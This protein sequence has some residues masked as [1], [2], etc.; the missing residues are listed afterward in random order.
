MRFPSKFFNSQIRLSG[1][2]A[3]FCLVALALLIHPTSV[4]ADPNGPTVSISGPSYTIGNHPFSVTITFSESVT[5]FEQDDVTVSNASVTEFSG[6]GSSYSVNLQPSASGTVTVD[7]AENVATNGAG[8]GNR[9]ASQYSGTVDMDPPSVSITGPSAVQTGAFD[10]DIEFSE[11]VGVHG[12]AF[13]Q[14]DV[15][16][17]NGSVT[18]FSGS[19][20]SYTATITPSANGTVT[21]DV[22]AKVT[23][24]A[25]GNN[26]TA[27]SQF[28]VQVNL[29]AAP[30]ITAPGNKTY[31]QGDT[32]TSFG[33]PVS[34]ADDDALS[35]TILNLPSGLTWSWDE[36]SESLQVTGTVASG[37]TAQDYKVEIEVNDQ[38]NSAVKATFT[39]TVLSA[40]NQPPEFT[41]PS[42][43]TY[44]QGD[45]IAAFGITVSDPDDY[46]VNIT[47][48]MTGLP[49][50]LSYTNGQV[51]GTVASD[52][53]AKD[54][55]VTIS[56]TDRVNT[57]TK[58]FTIRVKA[59]NQPPVIKAPENKTYEQGE[60][61][62]AFDITVTDPNEDP[63]TVTVSGLP[64]GLS[65]TNGQVQGTVAAN[66]TEKDYTV[67]I[68]ANEE[69]TSLESP[70]TATFTITV[71]EA[72]LE[73]P[74][75]TITG[76]TYTIGKHSFK[77]T[78]TFSEDVTGFEQSD[79]TVGNGSVKSF[80]GSGTSYEV[81][82]SPAASGTV[83][84][85]VAAN[86]A[87]DASGNGN[88]AASQFSVTADQDAPTVTIT[89]PTAVQTGAFSVSIEFS[90]AIDPN[91]NSF[92]QSDVTVGNGSV[93]AFSGSGAS[94]TATITPAATGTVTVDVAENA[95]RD[96]AGNGNEAASQFSVAADIDAP[97]VS[98]TGPTDDQE[99]AFD[100][101]IT[102]SE[103]VTGFEKEDVTVGNG[104]VTAFSGS[105]S[106]YTATITPTVSR[107]ATVDVAANVAEDAAGNNN[108]AASQ[109]SV[110]VYL[111]RWI[112]FEGP[113][114]IRKTGD[115]FQVRAIFSE[116]PVS[117]SLYSDRWHL[118][119]S[120]TWYSGQ[121]VVTFTVTPGYTEK[122]SGSWPYWCRIR[123]HWSDP[124]EGHPSLVATYQVDV[125]PDPPRFW[126][127]GV[128]GPTVPQNGPFNVS[129]GVT[130][131]NLVGFDA[132]DIT[133]ENGSVTSFKANSDYG[134]S[135]TVQITPAASGYVRVKVGAA[136]FKDGTG[137]DNRASPQFSVLADLDAP[138]VSIAGPTDTQKEPFDVTITFSEDV[139]GFEQGDVT[140]GNGTVTAFSGSDSSYTAT[141]TPTATGTVTVDVAA[142]VAEDVAT[143][144]NTAA[145]QF[146]VTADI[147][148][149]TVSITGPTDN[150]DSAFDVTITFSEDVT[151]FEQSDVT[152]GNGTVT[153]FSGSGTSY[154][155]TI[156]PA[157][158]GIVTV[159]VPA[160][161][162]TDG[163]GHNNEAASQFSVQVY[164]PRSIRFEGPTTVR[165]TEDPFQVKVIFSEVPE[166]YSFEPSQKNST[167]SYTGEGP[168][169]DLTLTPSYRND[170]RKGSWPYE[171]VLRATWF[172]VKNG[173]ATLRG[174][175]RV[176]VDADPPR[177]WYSSGITGPTAPQTGPFDVRLAA[178]EGNL[179]GFDA[180]DITVTNGTVTS[181]EA[182]TDYGWN[183]TVQITPTASGNVTVQVGAA[184][185]KDEAGHDN[186]ASR[187]FTVLAD[188]DAPTVSIT[189]PTDT[190][191]E[192]FDVT[193]TFSEDVTG[194]EQSDVTVGNGSI[195]AFSGSNATYT[196]TITPAATGTVTVDVPENVATDVVEKGNEAASQFSVNADLDAPTVTITGPTDDQNS[197]FDVTITFSESV[198]GFE[199]SDVTVGNGSVTAFSGSEDS[200]TATITPAANGT[201]TV[202]VPANVANDAA[203]NGNSAASQFAVTADFDAPTVSITGPTDP[204]N[205]AF[206]VTITFSESV[207]GFEQ[208]DITVGN[209]FVTAFS[210]SEDS[211]TATITPAAT[212]TVTVD[213][214]ADVANDVAGNSN[215]AASQF[216]VNADLD[217]PTVSITGP[218]DPQNSTFDV[219]IT[220]SEDVTGFEQ[221]DIAVGKGSITAFSG[222]DAT[223]T[224]TITP[225]GSGTVTVDVPA[226]IATDAAGNSNSAASQFAVKLKS[227]RTL[228][229]DKPTVSITGPTDPQNSTFDVT[230]T[231]S[232]DVTGFEQSEVTV[233]N[234]FV[235]AFSG[236]EAT[237]T[238][239]IAPAASGTVT[240]DVPE[241]AAKDVGNNGNEAASQF[242]VTADLDAPL[243]S[244]TGP[245]D[246]QNSAF[247]I[248]ITFTEAVTGFEQSD[249][250]VGNGAVT[251]FSGSE[252][253]YTATITPAG[254]GTV[255]VNVPANVAT[256]AAGNGNGAAFS[257]FTA[258]ITSP[259]PDVDKPTV[260]I[261][262]PTDDQ[263]SAF[264]VT[265]TFS[266]AVTGFEQNDITVG[267]GTATA[268]S[269]SED[270]YTA[271][272]TPTASGTVTVDVPAD[273]ATNG[274]TAASQFSV[275]ADL[276]RPTVT[277]TGPTDTQK[278]PFDLTITFSESVT[279]FEQ[280]DITV[281]NGAVTAFSGTEA[282][283]TVS[284]TPAANGT[285]TVD[286]PE[287]VATDGAGNGNT[288]A[289]SQFS[290][291]ANLI[292]PT[293][294][295]TGPTDDQNSAFDITITFSESVTGFEQSEVT[296]GNGTVT[297]FSGA[298]ATYTATI[299]PVASGTVTVDVPADVATDSA[300]NGNS[301][302]SQF[303]VTADLDAP[304]V[305]ITGP[306]DDQ[307]SAFDVTITFSESVT[308]F[309]QSEVTVGNGAVTAFSGSED[310]YTVTITP[311]AS[312]TVTVDIA[313]NVATDGAGNGNTAAASQFS[314]EANLTRPTVVITGPTDAQNSAF[315]V[316]ITFSESVTG[317]EQS[318]VT[319]GNGA[320]T[321][322]SGSEASYT[323]TIT[324][325]ANGTV[326]VDVPA[327]VANDAAG[328]GNEAASQFAVTADL[329][330]PTVT[331][332]GP[333]DPQNSA[334]D[335]TITFSESVTGFEQSEV[336]V[337]NG[338]ATAFSGSGA[339]YTV[340]ITP[341]AN[342][343]VTVDV[344]ANVANDAAGNGNS[345]AASQFAV[346]A[347]LER[348]TVTITGPTD[349]Q[350][351][352]FDITITFSA[353]VTGFEQGDI[354]VGNGA[355][356]AF[357][358]TQAAYTVTITPAANGTVTVDVAANV[359]EDAATNGNTAASQFSV[360]AD[361]E[362][363]TVTITGPTDDQ[364]STFDV[365]I[366]FSESVTGFEQ[367]DIT[368]GNGTA[369]A[370]SGSGATYT[371]T[372]TPTASGTITVDVAA[373]VAEDAA[374]NSNTAAGQFSVTADLERPT[375]TITGPT[376]DQNS[377]FDVTI[378]FSEAV[379]G[380]EQ[381]D[382]T[383]GNSSVTAFSGSGATYTAT[384][385]PTASGTITVDVAADVATDSAGNGNTAAASQFSVKANLTRP[386]V[387][388]TGPTDTQNSA[389]DVTITFSE[390]VTGFEQSDVTIG[391]GSITAFSGSGSSYTATITPAAS[392]T[393]TVDVSA[394]VATDSAGNGN[395]AASQFSVTTDIDAPTVSITGPTDPQNSAFDITITFSESVTGFEQGDITVGNGS[396]TAFSGSGASYTA[397]IEP[398]DNGTVTIDVPADVATDSAGNG[399]TAAAGQVSVEA[400]LTPPT[401]TI[402]GPTDT[403]NGPFD[404]TITFSEDVTEF[405]QDDITVGN[406]TVTTFSG[407]GNTYTA[408]ITP[409]ATGTVT[410]DIAE[411]IATDS[412]GNGNTAAAGQVSVEANLT[413][414]TVTITGPMDA[415]NSA[416]DITITFSESVTGFEQGDITVGNGTVTTFSGS[417]NTYTATITPAA[418]G[419]VTVDV[420]ADVATDSAG[421]GNSAASQFSVTADMDAPT[422]S[423]TGPT[424][425]QNSAF[426]ITIT[427]SESVTGFEQ[428]D[429]TVGN[430]TVTAF[431]G[432]GTTYTAT[433]TPTATGT[434]TVDVA[435]DVATDSAGNGNSAATSQ[436]S[437][438][439]DFNA[440]TVTITRPTDVQKDPFDITITFSED[441]T[442]F[443]QDDITVG[444][445]TV[446]A[447]SG[448]GTTYTVTITPT[449]TGTVTVNIDE[450][451]ATD[452]AGN[453]NNA[454][455]EQVSVEANL[456]PPSV[457][458]TGPTGASGLTAGELGL[459]TTETGG[460]ATFTV[461]L[462]IWPTAAVNLSISSS[463]IT[464]GTVAPQSLTFTA[465]N[466][467]IPQTVTITG[468]DDN[469][470]DGDQDY[471]I[472]LAATSDQP[473][474]NGINLPE[475]LVTNRDDDVAGITVTPILGLIV[476][477]SGIVSLTK[478][479]ATAIS[480]D[481]RL[482]TTER[483][484]VASFKVVL[485]S[486]PTEPVNL[487]ISSSDITE[488]IGT[489]Q[490]LTFMPN[491]E[492]WNTPQVITVAGLPDD[493]NDGDQPYTVTI[494]PVAS[495]DLKYKNIDPKEI[496][497]TNLDD[498]TLTTT[499]LDD[500]TLTDLTLS[501][502]TLTP[503]FASETTTYE[504]MIGNAVES[505]TV[506][507]TAS[508]TAA[509][510]V[511]NGTP[512]K[513]G[514]PSQPIALAIGAN[515]IEVILASAIYTL[516]VTRQENGAPAA[517]LLENQTATVGT[518]F[519]YA[520][521]EVNDPDPSQTVTYTAA[522]EGGAPLPTW[523]RF[524]AA[525]RAFSGT[526]ARNDVGV[527]SI[528]VTATDNG[529]P[530]M[531]ASMTFT[532]S[533]VVPDLNPHVLTLAL[534]TFGR[535]V[536][537][538]AVNAIEDRF[539]TPRLE[540]SYATLGGQPLTLR[541][542]HGV[543]GLLQSLAR[544]MGLNIN[545]PLGQFGAAS[546]MHNPFDYKPIQFHSRSARDILSQSRFGL[547]MG[548]ENAEKISPWSLWGHGSTSGFSSRTEDNLALDGRVF[549]GYL[550]IDYRFNPL[551]LG[552]ALS[553]S[554]GEIDYTGS[555]AGV[556]DLNLLSV[557][558]YMHYSAGTGLDIW[559]LGGTGRGNVQITDQYS[560]AQTDIAM[561]M[562]AVGMRN[563]LAKA[564]G[565]DLS[566]KSDAFVVSINSDERENLPVAQADVQRVRFALQGESNHQSETSSLTPRLE[567][568]GRWD[569]GKAETGIGA[570]I[571]GGL[572]YVHTPSGWGIEARGHY[573]IAHQQADFKDWSARI[574]LRFDP[575]IRDRGLRLA[576]SPVWGNPVS[577]TNALWDPT[578]LLDT[579]HSSQ[580]PV[581]DVRPQQFDIE[582]GYDLPT[583]G[584]N[585][586]LASYGGLRT[587]G[588]STMHYRLGSRLELD[589]TV[590]LN[591]EAE[592]RKQAVGPSDSR[593]I[594][595]GQ[596]Y[597]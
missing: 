561:I 82:I 31:K 470:D 522:L 227:T 557:I 246:T 391:N 332:T 97:T 221:N 503:T 478:T 288:A 237:Y 280:N 517:P 422:I 344:P 494:S 83:T 523:L 333:T 161:A 54:Y 171:C 443:G 55:T 580:R 481:S 245:T 248:T 282:T 364:N 108:T 298:G 116:P 4:Q 162:A 213:V 101:T 317:F 356:T 277:I 167:I 571:G 69:G 287:N 382:I 299:A 327:N 165:T 253:S 439:A 25:G 404:I 61:I 486:Q 77:V 142:N 295:I 417:G 558:P 530:S 541:A 85:D 230:I 247:D 219:T 547:R 423:I 152:I 307:N 88:E 516:T 342:G 528:A 263:N 375:V 393:V 567:L 371:A 456:T 359:A 489:P 438:T 340:T 273:V 163:V 569:G 191:K 322:F 41:P 484:H 347:D 250:T 148:A 175:Y 473:D 201:V 60:T 597:W 361:L 414:P 385:T 140:V 224:A 12:G 507:P 92:E 318:E 243:V 493:L 500:I 508:D 472:V 35:M 84:V 182:D 281:G 402:T 301:A 535:T 482:A 458:I 536:A 350:N 590:H 413:R 358:G 556:M 234:G 353:P 189:G 546:R 202:D 72:D 425:A 559:G 128:S 13:E 266:E 28:S 403:Q 446:T 352:A 211:Y 153:A 68:E 428:G 297:A 42:S 326:T 369:T 44:Y 349:D 89:G 465:T 17:G 22:A 239:T 111:P 87:T 16:V 367:S 461:V 10:V 131:G 283:Y 228:D 207:T 141:I 454:A 387:V 396:I 314:V 386:T 540:A 181:F 1:A 445:G 306:T 537:S 328:N 100:V 378:T 401:V 525:N 29:N 565:I 276:E 429:I 169:F 136:T 513:S 455:E 156:T 436:V 53:T 416:F 5:G 56:V 575:G 562:A 78:I 377:T 244:I 588:A 71:T 589:R 303:S 460:T 431:S 33:I 187:T 395:T 596:I 122:R 475:V 506:T 256:D 23:R 444:N 91:V 520:F 296:V 103:D 582:I 138:T 150:Q 509:T 485:D 492:S 595:Q 255:T 212:G 381:S 542:D 217:A 70:S 218:T 587:S 93:T 476:N 419:T 409:A 39:I 495:A 19:G 389:F 159:D 519:Q 291:E 203:D 550:G 240:V 294:T 468:V 584:K 274:N 30:V 188:L 379:T 464:E 487:S 323:V 524:D 539:T 112:R 272:I 370:F 490:S 339:S 376:D 14:D 304:T 214:S 18:A 186:R 197:V 563:A 238:A 47:V 325:A 127:R 249:V 586:V 551:T 208:S 210:G 95:A 400:N 130:E 7:I 206:D 49:S 120:T 555:D 223:Y 538:N 573:L 433:I 309:E 90:E 583:H 451:I 75:V 179:V 259:S 123:L 424:D 176:W 64:S 408:T 199:Q 118:T 430:G 491:T 531:S 453:G 232:E 106:S 518:A 27:A 374:T 196:A 225:E 585:G 129:L 290:V 579:A 37:A 267:N 463:D 355:V 343:T 432:S 442:G 172:G 320:V 46:D 134:D 501:K 544:S 293:V 262:G 450:N 192:P 338:T 261:T 568:G 510:I 183:Y 329:D 63:V 363:P 434:V 2:I 418:T 133:V 286:V 170:E 284:I 110:E 334:F 560:E 66:A 534:G 577:R 117:G 452:G 373:N 564:G 74:T 73:D 251:A 466:W 512:I 593:I 258:S 145:S 158:S 345:A 285:V 173:P 504:A 279:G 102:F 160:N 310:S 467:N 43:R 109:F 449:A 231:F 20:A 437:V 312:G 410:I 324:P 99:G 341:A 195:T 132:E 357:S 305:T 52:A 205:S 194:F 151:G 399:N 115:S 351:S 365:T 372:I 226:D 164:L 264:D 270:S 426:D 348:P 209:G 38:V 8:H 592:H 383:V 105:G 119:A 447:F 406:G 498:I 96:A 9:A 252:D 392:G 143:N 360:T 76:P 149:P 57:V 302:A 483:G 529:I 104:S 278:G 440:P 421:N 313:E 174:D 479:T 242:S 45:A 511:V 576:I 260:S 180:E 515:T 331:I 514:T 457:T 319:V 398:A 275:Q 257:Q 67:T 420:A 114:T 265:I 11:A 34:D 316:T 94:Y 415:Q 157:A 405:G 469:I 521:P 80:S 65:Y 268:F 548:Q 292:R 144:G 480:P 190:Q 222:S 185:F 502:G 477:Q 62:T 390:S 499:N 552:L 578:H 254:N 330:A 154:T 300:G 126:S 527:H 321:A 533:V 220:F 3:A 125:D 427:F 36:E 574:S 397:T 48:T 193:I 581:G 184:T 553:H 146:S 315:D 137:H 135:Y 366:T 412:A 549:S 545:L 26:N 79:V 488:G 139:T 229:V 336:T 496:L 216:A 554:T 497:L 271:T 570:E 113:T 448:S 471:K 462:N 269:G 362:R 168:A 411:N 166:A 58:T 474:Y 435:A 204:Q 81:E 543:I 59:S 505:L 177:F 32:I 121:S 233:G 566:L 572:G 178:T 335:I 459:T 591:I 394:D 384:I 198:T 40:S 289:A 21:V 241:N 86:V 388:I 380:F 200:Y 124:R 51:Q 50:G 308:G 15:T 354:T 215:S 441:V 236:T 526:P 155:A 6:S 24:D 532:L 407:S 147:D 346:T 98:I 311:A 337:G 107:T 594:L 368:V 235:T